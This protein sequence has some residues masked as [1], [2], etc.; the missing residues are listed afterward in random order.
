M[1]RIGNAL[2]RHGP[3]RVFRLAVERVADA[4]YRR[5]ELVFYRVPLEAVLA[6]ATTRAYVET[7]RFS[8]LSLEEAREFTGA[9]D[10]VLRALRPYLVEDRAGV[11]VLLAWLDGAVAGWN[12]VWVGAAEW[13]LSE[14]GTSLTLTRDDAIFY[15]AYTVPR[16]RGRHVNR[17]LMGETARVALERGARELWAWHEDWNEAP[18][19]NMTKVGMVRVGTHARMR[20]LGQ[21]LTPRCEPLR[22]E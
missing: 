9:A 4:I 10:D 3:G 21:W 15:S 5:K 14:T 20:L 8:L 1:S 13:P 6:D 18:R 17:A 7:C 11:S 12:M 22:H 19:K 16:F 2:R